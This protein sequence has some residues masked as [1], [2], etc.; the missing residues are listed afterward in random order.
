M[1]R[2]PYIWTKVKVSNPENT[3][4]EMGTGCHYRVVESNPTI[5]FR[6]TSPTDYFLS[7]DKRRSRPSSPSP[8][9]VP[10]E[11]HSRQK[12]QRLLADKGHRSVQRLSFPRE[13]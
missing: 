5:L 7:L 3:Y 8:T 4:S 13:T 9:V 1:S 11:D 12:S 6:G 2:R 10:V